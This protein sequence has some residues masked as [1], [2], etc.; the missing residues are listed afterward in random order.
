MSV[1]AV[2]SVRLQGRMSHNQTSMFRAGLEL[3]I[4]LSGVRQSGSRYR[5]YLILRFIN[6]LTK[7]IALVVLVLIVLALCIGPNSMSST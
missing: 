1:V 5:Q 3:T 4:R 2:Y 6:I 7:V